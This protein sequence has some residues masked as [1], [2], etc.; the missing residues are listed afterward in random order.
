[1]LWCDDEKLGQQARDTRYYGKVQS[2]HEKFPANT[3]ECVRISESL[4]K[5]PLG[6][7]K[8]WVE[9]CMTQM[10]GYAKETETMCMEPLDLREGDLIGNQVSFSREAIRQ[11]KVIF[12]NLD[13]TWHRELVYTIIIPTRVIGGWTFYCT[14]R[15]SHTLCLA[16]FLRKCRVSEVEADLILTQTD[17]LVFLMERGCMKKLLNYLCHSNTGERKYQFRWNKHA[18]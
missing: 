3:W 14:S 9:I 1:M 7:M 16:R 18:L 17:G 8:K 13:T 4:W 6:A 15:Y 5:P 10:L 12:E 2:I 11:V